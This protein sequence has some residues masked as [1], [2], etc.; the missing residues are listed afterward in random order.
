MMESIFLLVILNQTK[1]KLED[2][3]IDDIVY[4][5]FVLHIFIFLEYMF[6]MFRSI[7]IYKIEGIYEI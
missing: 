7:F 2:I 1:C 4:N 5:I 6:L 3:H